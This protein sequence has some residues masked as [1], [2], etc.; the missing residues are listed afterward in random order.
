M[1]LSISAATVEQ[2]EASEDVARNMERISQLIE[3]NLEAAQQATR[4]AH[5]L[6][7]TSGKLK[8]LIGGFRIH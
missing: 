3:G 8:D 6:L 7:D 2:T 5:E 1:S 4:A